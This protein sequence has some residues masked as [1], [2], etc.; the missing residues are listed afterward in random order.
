MLAPNQVSAPATIHTSSMPP[1][2]GTALLTSDGWTK[3]DDADDGPDHH[4]GRLCQTDCACELRRHGA[5]SYQVSD[6]VAIQPRVSDTRYV[7]SSA[8]SRTNIWLNAA[9][10]GDAVLPAGRGGAPALRRSLSAAG[11]R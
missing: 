6:T 7:R 5:E 3:I 8:R 1:N 11:G 10:A 4:R 9:A 2:D